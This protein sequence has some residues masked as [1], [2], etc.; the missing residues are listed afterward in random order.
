VPINIPRHRRW[1]S[2]LYEQILETASSEHNEYLQVSL[3]HGRLQLVAEQAIYSFGDYYL[4]FRKLFEVFDF[5][6]LPDRAQVL[7]LG[8]GLG[9]IPEL[10]ERH[11][12][13]TYDYVAVEIDPVIIELAAE[14][15]LPA[16][17]ST[18]EIQEA[19]ALQFLRLDQRKYDLICVDVFQ[20]AI[21]PA[22][23]NTNEFLTL[24]RARLASKGAIIYN[25]LA[26]TKENKKL[27]NNYFSGPFS[28]AFPKAK[29]FDSG[30]NFMLLNERRFL[31]AANN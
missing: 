8:L 28:R 22:H 24:L 29:I 17:A 26:D 10:L 27:A 2:Y 16:L 14:Y 9:S 19:D 18:I 1:L 21:I 30:G 23:L 20:D 15:S 25:R 13:L 5:D 6:Q 3:V 4:N 11:L 7:V 12:G 31:E